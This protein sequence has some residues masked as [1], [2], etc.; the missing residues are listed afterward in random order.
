MVSNAGNFDA[1]NS[2]NS[3]AVDIAT[4]FATSAFTQ[5]VQ[6]LMATNNSYMA[7]ANSGTQLS[8]AWQRQL[9][10]FNNLSSDDQQALVAGINVSYGQQHPGIQ[11]FTVSS[12]QDY[13]QA[14][15]NVNRAAEAAATPNATPAPGA[16]AL[17][18]L[19]HPTS[20]IDPTAFTAQ[21]TAYFNQYGPAPQ[22]T[23]DQVAA[24][25]AAPPPPPSSSSPSTDQ[26]R[27]QFQALAAVSDTSGNTS[28]SDQ[29]SAYK[30][31]ASGYG[32][33][34]DAATHMATVSAFTSSSFFSRV[35]TVTNSYQQISWAGRN[36]TEAAAQQ[37]QI[38]AFQSFSSEDQ[39]IIASLSGITGA[40]TPSDYL[41]YLVDGMKNASTGDTINAA[42]QS[43]NQSL[44]QALI[45]S[46][47][48]ASDNISAFVVSPKGNL[49]TGGQLNRMA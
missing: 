16:E 25:N 49:T 44:Y 5:H 6:S 2:N 41:S 34:T 30:Q 12:W 33:Q 38:N 47:G 39:T 45:A 35:Q 14:R 37:A 48:T 31:L 26:V 43:G 18:A 28:L 42:A 19:S 29:L 11:A 40:T 46:L 15:V 24:D 7:Q 23:A 20:Y 10:A 27:A 21:A 3:N 1:S 22:A 13:S 8:E 36:G 4:A 17:S 32:S 9:N